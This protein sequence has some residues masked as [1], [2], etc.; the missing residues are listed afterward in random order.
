MGVVVSSRIDLQSDGLH[1]DLPE[2]Q[3][4]GVLLGRDLRATLSAGQLHWVRGGNGVGKSTLLRTLAGG[5]CGQCHLLKFPFGLRLEMTV[6]QHMNASLAALGQ[7]S[8][9]VEALLQQVGLLD[10]AEERIQTLSSGQ[11]ARLALAVLSAADK[12]VWL[13]DEPLN[14]LDQDGLQML[15]ALVSDHVRRGGVV[16]LASHQSIGEMF[17][18]TGAIEPVVWMF[19]KGRLNG[20][21]AT[22]AASPAESSRPAQAMSFRLALLSCWR[23]EWLLLKANPQQ[24]GWM[25]L[26]HWMVISFFGLAVLKSDSPFALAVVWVSA[27]LAV[28]LTAKDW[29]SEDHRTGWLSFLQHTSAVGTDKYWLARCASGVVTQS[30]STMPVVLM[31][32]LQFALPVGQVFWLEL[33]LLCGIF[34]MTPLLG[35]VSLMV[36]MTRGGAILVYLLA[37][38]VLVPVLIFGLECSQAAALGRSPWAAFAVLLCLAGLSFMVAP[39]VARRLIAM[40]QE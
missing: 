19:E 27:I 15:G 13:L 34:A 23:R 8:A 39:P 30:A 7:S 35:L 31:A 4:G 17:G 28:L 5:V 12:K 25:A 14:A 29:F 40:I 21:E 10:W 33:A 6:A 24:L 22:A 26:F 3:A 20:G 2:L 18:K 1:F 16:V 37:L 38:P 32:G 11:Q 36:M 9:L